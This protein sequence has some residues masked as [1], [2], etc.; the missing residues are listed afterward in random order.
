MLLF[1]ERVAEPQVDKFEFL[2]FVTKLHNRMAFTYLIFDLDGTLS[3]Y[4]TGEILPGVTEW[5]AALPQ[6]DRPRF[7]LASN[8]G[9][10]GLRH[11]ME[12]EGFGKPENYPSETDALTHIAGVL[13]HLNAGFDIHV[14]FAYQSKKTGKFNPTPPGK[15]ASNEWMSV[16]RKPEAGM[17]VLAME[18]ANAAPYETLMV[19]D[20]D[21]DREAAEKAKC[22]FMD[23][24]EFFG[25]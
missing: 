20:W 2:F 24:A 9:G 7:A 3:E 22:D 11:W 18:N 5:F 17:L 8:Q 15:L 23:A 25:R 16:C 6:D 4:K 21:E 14:C 1:T 10:V 13:S 12:S 19:G